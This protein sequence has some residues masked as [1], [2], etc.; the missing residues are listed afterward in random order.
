M[1][2]RYFETKFGSID[3]N[4]H[5]NMLDVLIE[6]EEIEEK[7]EDTFDNTHEKKYD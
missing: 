7:S 4:K 1:Q 2:R 6:D 5:R 3:N